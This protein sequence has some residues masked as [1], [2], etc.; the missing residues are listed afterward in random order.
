MT[1]ATF[2]KRLKV[3]VQT[4]DDFELLL[5]DDGSVDRTLLILREFEAAD[6]RVHVLSSEN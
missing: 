3:F 5:L 1:S 4:F 2:I 6:S